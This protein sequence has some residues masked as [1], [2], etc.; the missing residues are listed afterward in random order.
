MIKDVEYSILQ[1]QL[2]E[3]G[4]K[5][6]SYLRT[7]LFRG[8]NE[9]SKVINLKKNNY[10]N[11]YK[12]KVECS[13]SNDESVENVLEYLFIKFN[14]NIPKE[15]SGRSLSVSDIIKIG[16]RY[17]YCNDIGFIEVTAI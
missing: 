5:R 6:F 15:Y 14:T 10:K 11:V 8:L 9:N 7:K 13:L 16:N 12:G 1:I 17:Y 4:D 2:V 3:K